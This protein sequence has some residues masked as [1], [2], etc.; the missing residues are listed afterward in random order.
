MHAGAAL[1]TDQLLRNLAEGTA[2]TTGQ[3]FFRALVRG[4]AQALDVAAV[5]VAEYVPSDKVLRALSFWFIDHYVENYE[6][7]IPG[8][9][10]EVA[11]KATGLVHYPE[12]IIELFPNDADLPGLGAVSYAG[13]PLLG[14]DREVLGHLAALDNKPFQLS[15]ELESVI[16]IFASRAAAELVRLRADAEV[17][18]SETRYA[19]LF[20]SAMDAILELDEQYRI[21]RANASAAATFDLAPEAL[22]GRSL[23]EL[24]TRESAKKL[25]SLAAGF[26]SSGGLSCWVPGGLEARRS[27]GSAFPAEASLSQFEWQGQRRYCIILRNVQKQL[28]AESRMREL[29]SEIAEL[30]NP[31][32]IAGRSPAMLAVL[33]AIQQVA[34]TPST[35]LISGETGTGKELVARAIHGSSPRAAKPFIRVNCAAIPTA[36]A[37]SEFFGHEKGAFTGAIGRRVGRFELAHGGTIFLDEIGELPLDLQAKLLRVLQEGE[38]EPVGSSQTRKVDVRMIAATNRDL[39]VEVRAGRFREDLYYRLN[40]FPIRV[41]PL[42]ERG[43]DVELLADLF[44]ERYCRQIG[45][46][47]PAFTPDCL[48]RL[49]SYSWPGNV[50]ELE[51]IVERAIIVSRGDH[52]SLRDALPRAAP[53]A[54]VPE[55]ADAR[56]IVARTRAELTEIEKASL[57][58]ALEAASWR[59]AGENGAAQAL[60]LPA[61]TLASRMKALGIRRPR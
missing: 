17:Q 33:A 22:T 59:V 13:I 49:R 28:A 25:H 36:L 26:E 50:R 2:S 37:E 24:L 19:R 40:V 46:V 3:D 51:N 8:T 52:L 29:E 4:A 57:L 35:V 42:R 45:R 9:P 34:P 56:R 23:P 55:D 32:E 1:R 30:R 61:S 6:Y 10:C 15:S 44:V 20:E 54:M 47:K 39:S 21:R 60:G 48:R 16:R 12:R 58:S 53:A 18:A 27:D 7:A 14:R 43:T 31:G 11:I 41:P 5:W 38:F